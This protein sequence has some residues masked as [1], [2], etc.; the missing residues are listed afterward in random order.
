MA[1]GGE[2]IA[3]FETTWAAIQVRHPQ[4]PEVVIITGTAAQRGG[5]RWGHHWPARWSRADAEGRVPELF[6]AGELIA[7]GAEA[8][9]E[10]MLHEAA[11]ALAHVRGVKDTSRQGNRYHNKRFA[12]LAREL[13]LAV[14]DKPSSADGFT[15]TALTQATRTDYADELAAIESAR[16]AYLHDP[17]IILDEGNSDEQD[18]DSDGADGTRA[19]RRVKAVCGCGRGGLQLTPAALDE[20]PIVC[21]L[22]GAPFLP[23]AD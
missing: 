8:V 21:G 12:G 9:L 18:D 3:T 4:V 5:D 6:L 22:C 1:A 19:G 17:S 11:H 15:D 13:S 7:R 23:E 10:T 2:I 20:G 16:L 14:P